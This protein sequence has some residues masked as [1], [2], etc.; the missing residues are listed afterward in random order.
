MIKSI[1]THRNQ[2]III[3]IIGDSVG[4][5]ICTVGVRTRDAIHAVEND[6][7]LAC[8]HSLVRAFAMSTSKILLQHGVR[9]ND[10]IKIKI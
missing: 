5:F 4:V 2:I 7:L 9:K 1:Q 10:A 8:V 6:R 3:I